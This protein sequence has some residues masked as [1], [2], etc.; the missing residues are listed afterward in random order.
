ME[1]ILRQIAE[2]EQQQRELDIRIDA[3]VDVRDQLSKRI[4]EMNAKSES[5]RDR[6][7]ALLRKAAGLKD[8]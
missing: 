6:I 8:A 5:L 4:D 2:L 1:D 3:T 7:T